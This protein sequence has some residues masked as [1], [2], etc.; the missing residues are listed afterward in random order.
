MRSIT[1]PFRTT[2]ASLTVYTR[3]GPRA[4]DHLS[5]ER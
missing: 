5:S 1:P 3:R 2:P 4:L